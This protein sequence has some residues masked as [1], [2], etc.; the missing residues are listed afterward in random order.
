MGTSRAWGARGRSLPVG[1]RP[2]RRGRV[3]ALQHLAG[4]LPR[5]RHR[6]D[7][8]AG[9]APVRSYIPNGLGLWQCV[10]NVWEWCADRF[11][12]DAYRHDAAVNPLGP[13]EGEERVTRGESFLCHD[14]Y[15]YRYRAAAR[16]GNTA[17]S[18]SSNTGFRTVGLG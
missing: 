6:E 17:D 5:C 14:S 1:R 12:T 4:L 9:T 13:C 16:T 3:V 15:C 8:H 2:A 11:A 18:S 10:G 7:G